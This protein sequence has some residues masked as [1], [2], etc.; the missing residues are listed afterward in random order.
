VAHSAGPSERDTVDDLI[1]PL[2]RASGWR[3]DQMTFEYYLQARRTVSLGTPR[4]IGDG[5]A[6][7]V[8]EALPGAPVAVVEAKRKYRTAADAIQQAVRYAQQLD[9]P[10]AYGSNGVEIIE[11]NL[12]TGTERRVTELAAPALAW[13]EYSTMH[14]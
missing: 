2:L 9:V 8:L 14:G 11:R 1:V 5:F 10:L 4:A 6:D 3:D 13:S 7:I 12:R